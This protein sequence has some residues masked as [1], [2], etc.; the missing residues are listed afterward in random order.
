MT[1]DVD[2][3]PEYWINKLECPLISKVTSFR[4]NDIDPEKKHN[5]DNIKTIVS[6]RYGKCT[7]FLSRN[8]W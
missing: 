7:K 1:T 3:E 6:K 5:K 4:K 2:H 8:E